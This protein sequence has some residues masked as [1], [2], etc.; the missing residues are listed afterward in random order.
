VHV[1]EFLLHLGPGVHIEI[2]IAALPEPTEFGASLW[3]AERKLTRALAFSGPEGA[4][5]SLLETLD[6]LGGAGAAGLAQKQVH[7]L[8]HENVANESK[9]V[10]Q[11]GLLEGANGQIAG[12]NGVQKRPALVATKGNE[13]QIAK[14]SDAS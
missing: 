3:K 14:T 7:M 5:D 2:I 10:A 8:G 6:D 12:S 4:G 11:A 9:A 13:M 1:A